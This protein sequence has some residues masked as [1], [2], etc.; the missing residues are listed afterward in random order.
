[1]LAPMPAPRGCEHLDKRGAR[2]KWHSR[3]ASHGCEDLDKRGLR[4]KSH[5]PPAFRD[6]DNSKISAGAA[7][8]CEELAN[9]FA[10]LSQ[11][12]QMS[13]GEGGAAAAGTHTHLPWL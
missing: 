3:P 5:N 7:D 13:A 10:S 6:R 2:A 12:R 8:G 11:P 9:R 4:A 1:M